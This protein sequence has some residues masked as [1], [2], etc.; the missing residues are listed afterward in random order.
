MIKKLN[1]S[2]AAEFLCLS[3]ATLEVWRCHGR[4]PK[5]ARLG[6]R[7]VYD[8]ADLESFVA[9]QKVLTRDCIPPVTI[10]QR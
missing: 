1:T 4:G 3:P 10:V 2:Q 7:V 9:G 8:L 5:F 6:R